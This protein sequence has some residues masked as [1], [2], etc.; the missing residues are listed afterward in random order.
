M[1]RIESGWSTS[2][3]IA[4][5]CPAIWNARNIRPS[6]HR[7]ESF[8]LWALSWQRCTAVAKFP[9]QFF[10][11]WERS[12]LLCRYTQPGHEPG[13]YEGLACS[14]SRSES[15]SFERRIP[16]VITDLLA[17]RVGT[18]MPIHAGSRMPGNF[19]DET[20]PGVGRREL[21]GSSRNQRLAGFGVR[22]PPT[23]AW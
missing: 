21:D 9:A 2:L 6:I 11:F 13:H 15:I 19:S 3:S 17:C 14:R 20:Q 7:K 10:S 16:G 18:R 5:T 22:T 12:L 4:A 23:D 1:R 8:C